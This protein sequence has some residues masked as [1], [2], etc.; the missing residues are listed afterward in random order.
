MHNHLARQMT[1]KLALT[2]HY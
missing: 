2:N 1:M